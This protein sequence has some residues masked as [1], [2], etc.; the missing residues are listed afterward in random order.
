MDLANAK[1]GITEFERDYKLLAVYGIGPIEWLMF[2]SALCK[3]TRLAK[4]MEYSS[5]MLFHGA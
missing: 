1:R 2:I 3:I 5:R 4:E